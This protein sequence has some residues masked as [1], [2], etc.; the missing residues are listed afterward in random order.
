MK[1]LVDR[2]ILLVDDSKEIHVLVEK[3]CSAQGMKFIG[4]Y[5][6]DEA[7]L[8]CGDKF[9]HLVLLDIS[10]EKESGIS[11][12]ERRAHNAYLAAIPCIMF[13]ASRAVEVINRSLEL[14]AV[15]YVM[16]P[17]ST[18][19]LLQKI[20][21]A[22]DEQ[23][24]VFEYRFSKERRPTA[25]VL[26]KGAVGGINEVCLEVLLPLKPFID[27]K[28]SFTNESIYSQISPSCM[29][30]KRFSYYSGTGNFI[31]RIFFSGVTEEKRQ[32]I[33]RIGLKNVK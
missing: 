10:L 15:D 2:R 31:N 14:G 20:K 28:A 30:S 32:L 23:A 9:P 24:Q 26:M 21:R 4:C 29:I 19:I 7:L 6:V 27:L 25:K 17:F 3:V 11:F 22:L 18:K 5:T 8:Q 12:L 16:K 13:S 33:R 1:S